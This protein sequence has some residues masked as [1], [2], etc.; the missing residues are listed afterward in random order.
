[1]SPS[2][3]D[4]EEQ[5]FSRKAQVFALG[6]IAIGFFA[7][8]GR[9]V[10]SVPSEADLYW[11]TG[12]LGSLIILAAGLDRLTEFSFGREGVKGSFLDHKMR[13]IETAS[14]RVEIQPPG[15]EVPELE[16]TGPGT[17]GPEVAELAER[18]AQG[19]M[20]IVMKSLSEQLQSLAIRLPDAPEDL[21]E[22][23]GKQILAYLNKHS[24]LDA[25]DYSVVEG[26]WELAQRAA[27]GDPEVMAAA[28]RIARLAAEIDLGI[29]P[30]ERHV[31][32]VIHEASRARHGVPATIESH[33]LIF[34]TSNQRTW[35]SFTDKGLYCSLDNRKKYGRFRVQW[36]ED[37]A[38]LRGIQVSTT[39]RPK[40]RTGLLHIG[41]HRNWLFTKALF[42]SP[43]ALEQTIKD[44]IA[45]SV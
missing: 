10:W 1:M 31:T 29:D 40:K 34:S 8:L 45:S 42:A 18:D 26:V 25:A 27:E 30:A 24:V 4:A 7:A 14:Q 13:A 21:V 16:S 23:E 22:F 39:D 19:A 36:F 6:V 12:V 33:L 41:R 5:R 17:I 37:A 9:L 35:L 28:P 38:D 3:R 43:E 11:L 44:G 32:Q 2:T 15:E 20:S